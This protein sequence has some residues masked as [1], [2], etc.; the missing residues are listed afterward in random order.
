MLTGFSAKG[1]S[2]YGERG[3][4][5]VCA[6]ISAVTQSTVMGLSEVVGVK[7]DSRQ[8]DDNG[9][10]EAAILPGQSAE[11]LEKS[12]ILLSTL[13]LTLETIARNYPGSIRIDTKQRR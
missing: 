6:A 12:Q 11:L 8:D 1:H 13:E 9:S 4:D 10:L 5:I 7:L 2:G 3:S